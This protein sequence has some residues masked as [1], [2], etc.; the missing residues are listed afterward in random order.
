MS[1]H[2]KTENAWMIKQRLGKEKKRK[3]K[4]RQELKS[5]KEAERKNIDSDS[6]KTTKTSWARAH[7]TSKG[8]DKD[9]GVLTGT[10]SSRQKSNGASSSSNAKRRSTDSLFAH[11]VVARKQGQRRGK[12][13]SN[14]EATHAASAKVSQ[15]QIKKMQ[16]NQNK[17]KKQAFEHSRTV[18]YRTKKVVIV[19]KKELEDTQ[20]ILH[21]ELDETEVKKITERK[22]KKKRPST[23]R[24][25]INRNRKKRWLEANPKIAAAR[26]SCLRANMYLTAAKSLHM[27]HVVPSIY[28]DSETY[29]AV[30][31]AKAKE[32]LDSGR[33]RKAKGTSENKKHSKQGKKSM[34]QGM[35]KV[36]DG[37]PAENPDEYVESNGGTDKMQ[38]S[39]PDF[40]PLP[41]LDFPPLPSVGKKELKSP[42]KKDQSSENKSKGAKN[43]SS[44]KEE[45]KV[46]SES[47]TNKKKKVNP[48]ASPYPKVPNT[49]FTR[50][51]V[52]Q[53]VDSAV[54]K[55]V[56]DMFKI[57]VKL[58]EKL[59]K[60]DPERAKLRKRYVCGTREVLRS[61]KKKGTKC[62]IMATN[63][64]EC[65]ERG[66]LDETHTKI[67]ENCKA[68]DIP[69]IYALR[70]RT[71]GKAL[72]KHLK[73]SCVAVLNS[74]D[75]SADYK[76]LLK[77]AKER[78]TLYKSMKDGHLPVNLPSDLNKNVVL[79][80]KGKDIEQPASIEPSRPDTSSTRLN[81]SAG[82][83]VP[84]F[85]PGAKE[86]TPASIGTGYL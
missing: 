9:S 29:A 62:I 59:R 31:D 40:P 83:F 16:Q 6:N 41:S 28:T 8:K 67:V 27:E 65:A 64:D 37:M 78:R 71:L 49:N 7:S 12:N 45:K 66:G 56:K 82:E 23:L 24:K 10:N 43:P 38:L 5:Q 46:G 26:R 84:S 20:K 4:Q 14:A 74:D 63:I 73:M 55:K 53:V 48:F 68:N 36:T 50:E 13:K 21:G 2:Q 80:R 33:V 77:M 86:W 57:L 39:N 34:D 79:N 81:P 1:K 85:N 25:A 61:S 44:I 11:L 52:D 70:R 75:A 58:Q 15:K 3:E 18:E 72:G 60:T 76:E 69:L 47:N 19:T 42:V 32:N 35:P 22:K 30:L 54:G 17:Q 51:Y